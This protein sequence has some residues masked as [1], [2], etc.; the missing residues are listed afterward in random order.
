MKYL[1]LLTLLLTGCSDS[2]PVEP[3]VSLE[4]VSK[5]CNT[6]SV[7]LGMTPSMSTNT[8]S[9]QLE[10][11]CTLTFMDGEGNRRYS[12]R[13]AVA[14]VSI[15]T[16]KANVPKRAKFYACGKKAGAYRGSLNDNRDMTSGQILS[17]LHKCEKET[18]Y[19]L[20]D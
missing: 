8:Y 2:K 15:L 10:Y 9:G 16:L 17:I 18:G 1:L 20:W 5:A 12:G 13:D 7:E 3:D 6:L 19:K 4:T 14:A 11:L